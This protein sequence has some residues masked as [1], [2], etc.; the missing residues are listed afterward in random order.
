MSLNKVLIKFNLELAHY[1]SLG[2]YILW[3]YSERDIF[4][5]IEAKRVWTLCEFPTKRI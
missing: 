3:T 2:Q 1:R 5:Y 4:N